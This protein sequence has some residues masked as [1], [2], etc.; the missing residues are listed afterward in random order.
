MSRLFVL[1]LLGSALTAFADP[2]PL[3]EVKALL[4]RIR[5]RRAATPNMEADFREQRKVHLLDKP[6]ESS[7][8]IWFQAPNKFRREAKGNA[9]SITVSNG[10]E[11]WIY[12][13]NFKSAERYTLARRSPLD[14]GLSALTAGLNLQNLE[15]TYR[16]T[17][18]KRGDLYL[19]GLDPKGPSIRR[20]LQH[21]EIT[22]NS[23]LQA[24]RT[25]MLQPNGDRIVTDYSNQAAQ[26][27]AP[28][29]FTFEPP[30]GTEVSTPLGR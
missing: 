6:I 3:A 4:D 21:L 15:A 26:V 1:L 23:D 9:P 2:L 17:G 14:A 18:E 20:F 8:R 28:S 12:Y 30:P 13:P 10:Q 27:I 19:L 25:E 7:G 24:I 16:V 29:Q 5:E 11:L 22:L